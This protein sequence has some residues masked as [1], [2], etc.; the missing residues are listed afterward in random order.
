MV[1]LILSTSSGTV[2]G[3]CNPKAKSCQSQG[4]TSE[5]SEELRE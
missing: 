1:T 3:A 2:T 5:L 4:C